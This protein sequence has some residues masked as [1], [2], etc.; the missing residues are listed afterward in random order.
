MSKVVIAVDCGKSETKIVVIKG[1]NI[2]RSSFPTAIGYASNG[3]TDL[4]EN[5]ET[6]S[7]K[8]L[9]D[10]G[11]NVKIGS[12]DLPI[13]ADNNFSKDSDI[14]KV[15]TMYAIAKNVTPGDV[16][17]V[18]V[19]CPLSIYV[20]KEKRTEYGR[21]IVPSG[22]IEC[23]VNDKKIRFTIEKKMVIAEGTGP[24]VLH[25]DFFTGE[26]FDAA[27]IDIGSLNMNIACIRNGNISGESVHTS[28]HG[29]RMLIAEITKSFGDNEII[30]DDIQ[31][32]NAI[33]RGY[34]KCHDESKTR[35]SKEIIDESITKYIDEVEDILKKSWKNYDTLELFF[36]GGTSFLLK[37][38]LQERFGSF[39]HF[40][41]NFDN[42]R[43]SNSEGF[44]IKLQRKIANMTQ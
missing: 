44:A 18:A 22:E 36:I 33:Q 10:I 5:V 23:L 4:L 2:T 27:I 9:G 39:A 17:N 24:I 3:R 1:E 12:E 7:C 14:N 19:G 34:I 26:D 40:E 11:K 41:D 8:A 20:D 13:K 21:N 16:I 6:F 30:A 43:F 32:R 38:K 31:I 25:S 29:G 42:A 37:K 35:K 15:C 28:S